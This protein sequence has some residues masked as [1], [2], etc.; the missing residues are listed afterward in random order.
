ML[1]IKSDQQKKRAVLSQDG[2]SASVVLDDTLKI[3]RLVYDLGNKGIR[4]DYERGGLDADGNFIGSGEVVTV[5]IGDFEDD[6][7]ARN[8][9]FST[10][11]KDNKKVIKD[12]FDAIEVYVKS[13]GLLTDLV[14]PSASSS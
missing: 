9:V 4:I 3:M 5:H 7:V 2:N 8:K 6:D 12:F 11:R 10:F 13:A 14:D 1:K